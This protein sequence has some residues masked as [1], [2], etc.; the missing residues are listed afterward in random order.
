MNITIPNAR[1]GEPEAYTL[2]EAVDA[3]ARSSYLAKNSM[4][5]RMMRRAF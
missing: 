1:R 5:G 4:L 2:R 3:V